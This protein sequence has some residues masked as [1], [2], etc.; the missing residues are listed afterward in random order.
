MGVGACARDLVNQK[1]EQIVGGT[2]RVGCRIVDCLCKQAGWWL[3]GR[4]GRRAA[5]K[6]GGEV[7]AVL[8]RVSNFRNVPPRA[9]GELSHWPVA[10]SS[11]TQARSV[12]YIQ[13]APAC[14]SR[15]RLQRLSLGF[16]GMVPFL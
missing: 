14:A 13:Y 2:I 15:W 3:R 1:V 9:T 8:P 7:V 6:G 11:R 4:N 12:L 5:N 10:I 16:S